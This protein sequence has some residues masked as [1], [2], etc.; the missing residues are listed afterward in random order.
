MNIYHATNDRS[1]YTYLIGWT[2]HNIWYYG[3]RYA[4]GCHP[5]EFWIKY[6][7]SSNYVAD[8]VAVHGD[9]DII[10]IRKTFTNVESA[11]QWETKVLK[12]L[13]VIKLEKW[14]N[15][16]DGKAVDPAIL[17]ITT[18]RMNANMTSE[19][20]TQRGKKGMD[21]R[22]STDSSLRPIIEIVCPVCG[23]RIITRDPHISTCSKKCGYINRPSQK[24]IPK[25]KNSK[26]YIIQYPDNTEHIITGLRKFC[27]EHC[28]TERILSS[29][30]S[31]KRNKQHKGYKIVKAL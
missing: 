15:K 9:P 22:W 1:P 3:V 8:F 17:S 26:T 21:S 25:L 16:H 12:R 29:T 20:K 5:S 2:K 30:L 14:L 13:K 7:T 18:A 4:K 24:N 6:K 28:L 10:Q 19:E 23:T 27:I 11:R 31:G